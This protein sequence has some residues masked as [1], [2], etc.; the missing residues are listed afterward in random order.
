MAKETFLSLKFKELRVVLDPQTKKEV[1]GQ[2]VSTSLYGKF[3]QG[4]VAEFKNGVFT[5]SDEAVIEALK[6]DPYYGAMFVCASDKG[7]VK[8][9]GE[10]A[11]MINEKKTTAEDIAS[12]CPTC[13]F[14]A[15]T[16]QG[17]E[18]H[19]RIHNKN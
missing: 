12:T 15:K 17:L 10:A 13:G 1:Q 3:P 9:G 18:T 4:F 14:K 7:A 19:M 5:T 16:K 11:R 6:A 2:A 8:L